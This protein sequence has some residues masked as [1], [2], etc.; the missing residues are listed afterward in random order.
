MTSSRSPLVLLAVLTVLV[1]GCAE[2][3][4]H[5]DDLR[6]G[7]QQLSDQARFCLAL[8]RTVTAIESGSPTT[9]AEAAEEAYAQAPSD[10]RDE[11]AT[12]VDAVRAARDGEGSGLD[13]PEVRAAAERL[14]TRAEDLC[15]PRS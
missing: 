8:A 2:V 10:I 6:D 4:Q 5:A 15:D 1:A 12:V 3:R 11:A 14:R 7:A 13:D 9:A